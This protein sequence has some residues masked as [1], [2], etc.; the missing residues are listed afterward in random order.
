MMVLKALLA[1][2]I[3]VGLLYVQLQNVIKTHHA[4]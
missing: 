2:R 3:E 4:N 1:I